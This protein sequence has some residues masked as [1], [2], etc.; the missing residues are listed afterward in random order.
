[1]TSVRIPAQQAARKCQGP[2]NFVKPCVCQVL[3]YPTIPTVS[4]HNTDYFLKAFIHTFTL[5]YYES[6]SLLPL[7]LAASTTVTLDFSWPVVLIGTDLLPT[8]STVLSAAISSQ[9]GVSSI[10]PIFCSV[11]LN[12]SG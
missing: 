8:K 2:P 4:T 11:K 12:F 7:A 5:E 9:M 10:A 1:M 3:V 6:W